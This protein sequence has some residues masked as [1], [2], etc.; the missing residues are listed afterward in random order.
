MLGGLGPST[1]WPY[2][3]MTRPSPARQ[4]F[5]A[6]P[7]C[8]MVHVLGPT[9]ACLPLNQSERVGGTMYNPCQV[10]H[11]PVIIINNTDFSIVIDLQCTNL[12]YSTQHSDN[13]IPVYSKFQSTNRIT[14]H[15]S[16]IY[17][18]HNIQII[19]HNIQNHHNTSE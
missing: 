3:D 12:D 9:P 16:R 13:R 1:T 8:T 14:M 4:Q 5:C 7:G 10:A 6:R 17:R 19:V 18:I 2:T 11:Q 15:K